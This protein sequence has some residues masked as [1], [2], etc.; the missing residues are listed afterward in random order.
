MSDR[1]EL[2]HTVGTVA[3]LRRTRTTKFT[4]YD[5]IGALPSIAGGFRASRAEVAA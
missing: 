2:E 3:R 4:V 5:E 1:D